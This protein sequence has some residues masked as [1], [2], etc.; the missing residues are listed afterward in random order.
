MLGSS[1]GHLGK[2]GNSDGAVQCSGSGLGQHVDC[3]GVG[4]AGMAE[5][6]DLGVLLTYFNSHGPARRHGIPV[7]G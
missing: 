3:V 7:P 2:G 4:Y 1:S 5:R 6:P